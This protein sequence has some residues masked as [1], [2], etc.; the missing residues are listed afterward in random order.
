MKAAQSRRLQRLDL[1]LDGLS[2]RDVATLARAADLLEAALL[3][4]RDG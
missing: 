3:R 1:L 4:R 2:D